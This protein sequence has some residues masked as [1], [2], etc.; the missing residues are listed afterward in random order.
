MQ[1]MEEELV[2]L[3]QLP[4]YVWRRCAALV[5][6]DFDADEL[7]GLALQ[8]A[9]VSAGYVYNDVFSQLEREPLSLA[10]GDFG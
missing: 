7:R 3:D 4:H 2:Y 6:A 8:S 1:L 10:Q 5:S 9:H